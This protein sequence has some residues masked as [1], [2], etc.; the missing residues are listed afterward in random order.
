[1]GV[2]MVDHY[3]LRTRAPIGTVAQHLGQAWSGNMFRARA[4]IEELSPY[5]YR[6]SVLGSVF[7]VELVSDVDGSTLLRTIVRRTR[8]SQDKLLLVI[9][10][11]AKQISANDLQRTVVGKL[12]S[13]SLT[14]AGFD[15]QVSIEKGPVMTS[16]ILSG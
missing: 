2:T 4:P 6:L 9:P 14:E 7:D 12:L 5:N 1:M 8:I 13:R 10:F 11:G 15:V 3:A 16:A